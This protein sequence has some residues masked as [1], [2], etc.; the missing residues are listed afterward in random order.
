M[1]TEQ[2][3]RHNNHNIVIRRMESA[4]QKTHGEPHERP[5]ARNINVAYTTRSHPSFPLAVTYDYRG[6][7]QRNS[8]YANPN[9]TKTCAVN[10]TNV[11]GIHPL[12]RGSTGCSSC[13]AKRDRAGFTLNLACTHTS[14]RWA[15]NLIK[16][17]TQT[18]LRPILPSRLVARKTS[19]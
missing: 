5:A 1:G 8:T 19:H 9:T 11:D 2:L 14:A 10:A 17:I 15:Y 7:N 12:R 16:H 4:G 6:C 18:V 3:L 13:T